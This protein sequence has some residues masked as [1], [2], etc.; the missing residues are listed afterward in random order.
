M[1]GQIAARGGRRGSR[2]C[3]L[4]R[5]SALPHQPSSSR[6]SKNLFLLFP[7]VASLPRGNH[8]SSSP[9]SRS[10]LLN[11]KSE[12]T[13]AILNTQNATHYMLYTIHHT[14]YIIHHTSYT[15]VQSLRCLAGRRSSAASSSA[16]QRFLPRLLPTPPPRPR[17]LRH[18]TVLHLRSRSPTAGALC[19]RST[20][21]PSKSCP[22]TLASRC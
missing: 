7:M 10:S 12:T 6:G 5:Q 20:K 11:Q 17:P 9:E 19:P 8:K 21:I 4:V 14:S 22:L 18:F 1:Y 15:I 16:V 2:L 13:S 3:V